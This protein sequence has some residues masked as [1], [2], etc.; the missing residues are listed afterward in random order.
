MKTKTI[1]ALLRVTCAAA[2][3]LGIGTVGSWAQISY[4]GVPASFSVNEQ[5]LRTTAAP[6]I[7]RVSPNFNPEDEIAKTEWVGSYE[8]RPMLKPL[9]IGRVIEQQINFAR[10]AKEVVLPTGQPVYRLSIESPGARAMNLYFDDFFIP[11]DGGRLYVYSPNRTAVL[12]AFTYDTHPQHGRF[13]IEP[14]KSDQL[15]LEY[16]VGQ[17]GELPSLLISGVNYIYRSSVGIGAHPRYKEDPGEGGSVTGCQR[18]VNCPEGAN[19]Q[20][21]KTGVIQYIVKLP[22]GSTGLCSADLVN[23]TK[24]D[25]SPL[26]LT[27]AHCLS[28]DGKPYNSNM[29]NFDQWIFTFH[30]EKPGCSNSPIAIVRAKSMVG[31]KVLAYMPI[32]GQSD[33]MLL[34]LNQEVPKAFRVYYNGWDTNQQQNAEVV[35][36]HHP[37]GDAKKISWTDQSSQN[38]PLSTWNGS[39]GGANAHFR[40]IFPY[41]N[42]EGGSSGSS[43]FNTDG[44]VIGTLTGGFP[45]CKSV[46][47][48]YGR[49][50]AHWNAYKKSGDPLTSMDIHLDP[51]NNGTTTKLQGTWREGLRPLA[52]ITNLQ[53]KPQGDDIVVT[54]DPV[55]TEGLPA[56]WTI[57]Y[58]M[59]RNGKRLVNKDVKDGTTFTEPRATALEGALREGSVVYGVQATY[60]YNGM[61]LPDDGYNGGK[62]YKYGVADII[63]QGVYIGPAVHKVTPSVNAATA[64]G[65]TVS[66]KM[67]GNLQEVS[68]FGYPSSSQPEA[69]PTPQINFTWWRPP[70]KPN[71]YVLVSR[72]RVD[73]FDE[74]DTPCVYEVSFIPAAGMK[75]T[76]DKKIFIRNG[77]MF[78]SAPG[79]HNKAKGVVYEEPFDL[80]AGWQ[81]GQWVTI[82]LK[83]P[84]KVKTGEELLVGISVP[85]S[86]PSVAALEAMS[87][88]SD[89]MVDFYDGFLVMDP[90]LD[91]NYDFTILQN[92]MSNSGTKNYLALRVRFSNAPKVDDEV[93][94][95]SKGTQPV[96]FPRILGYKIVKNGAV[97]VEKIENLY[98]YTDKDGKLEDKYEVYPIYA[99]PGFLPIDEVE[100]IES[101]SVYPSQL[102]ADA[103]LYLSNA[104]EVLNLSIFSLDGQKVFE[105]TK[106]ASRVDLS[107]LVSGRYMVVL[108]TA[109]NQVSQQITK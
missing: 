11:N 62:E 78:H 21:Q 14:L 36:I 31:C 33:G 63:E 60:L 17:S 93:V 92:R 47:N 44:L 19:W 12:G 16:E 30:Y 6:N 25:F 45:G 35:G 42:V 1:F 77:K 55:K 48:D 81:P 4:G 82:R 39:Q 52:P 104:E 108:Q 29:A 10:E 90:E 18:N 70:Y 38:L 28:P 83:Q 71:R 69:V 73:T 87:G 75:N 106:P 107:Q 23:N 7:M 46:S 84:Y 13:A 15:I 97:L 64:G 103:S 51:K 57:L 8:E 49:M 22:D 105:V 53:I 5:T 40:V 59:Y 102:G 56:E 67:P 27:A 68:L 88:T 20:D 94:C 74:K 98:F 96:P 2:L 100:K 34:K 86:Y 80:P 41:N 95:T 61:T 66:W 85:N 26:V 58:R 24:Q 65:V 91:A 37:A 101:P 54:W 89:A 109:H 32:K 50:G 43:L 99:E 72:Y 79:G 76:K 3:C 9:T